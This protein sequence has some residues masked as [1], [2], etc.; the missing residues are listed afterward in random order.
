[1]LLHEA[2]TGKILSCAYMVHSELGP[3]LLENAY[4]ECLYYE[5][6][7]SGFYVERQKKMPLLY[8]GVELDVGYRLDLVVENTVIIELK[9]VEA[10]AP[11]HTAQL[12][13]YLNLSCLPI[14]YL[15]N[16]NVTSLKNGIKRFII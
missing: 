6:V 14:G 4:E 2:L 13:T 10:F 1:M 3:G 7:E 15:M 12:L 8:K 9:A 11:I 5:L 16:F